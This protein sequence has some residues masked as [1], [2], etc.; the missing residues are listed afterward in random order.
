MLEDS[1]SNGHTRRERTKTSVSLYSVE[2]SPLAGF[3]LLDHSMQPDISFLCK[4][5]VIS[6]SCKAS[7]CRSLKH[8]QEG[9]DNRWDASLKT[10]NRY[11]SIVTHW[12]STSKVTI[13][14]VA[15]SHIHRKPHFIFST[16]AA[17]VSMLY[18]CN[19][20][21]FPTTLDGERLRRHVFLERKLPGNH[22]EFPCSWGKFTRTEPCT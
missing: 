19:N 12:W 4:P 16:R 22:E 8:N 1:I 17:H 2:C 5:A 13:S 9:A 7:S 6:F 21:I 3:W 18:N 14:R 10:W 11:P 15:E 20:T